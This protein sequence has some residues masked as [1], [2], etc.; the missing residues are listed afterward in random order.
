MPVFVEEGVTQTQTKTDD[1]PRSRWWFRLVFVAGLCWMYQLYS[2]FAL[3]SVAQFAE[4]APSSTAFMH[5]SR[6]PVHYEWVAMDHIA[7]ALAR[8]VVAGEDDEYYEHPGFSWTAIRRAAQKNWER[9]RLRYGGSTI[10]QQVAKNLFLSSDKSL[11]RKYKELLIALTLERDLSK[12]RILE[13]YLNIVEWGPGIYGAQ[14]ASQY[15]FHHNAATLSPPQAAFL[16]AILPNP[17]QLG[18]HGFRLNA[19]A[20]GILKRM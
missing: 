12:E 17:R 9:G 19:R 4:S 16:A 3:P 5:T 18:A 7:P 8:A 13:I 14:A 2:W 6:D 1:A 10:T 15:Y 20:R 11:F